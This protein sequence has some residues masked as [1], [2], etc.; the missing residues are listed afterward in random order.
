[1]CVGPGSGPNLVCKNPLL[2]NQHRSINQRQGER[3]RSVNQAGSRRKKEG[4]G[5][6]IIQIFWPSFSK[7]QTAALKVFSNR[8]CGVVISLT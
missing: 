6:C 5:S 4:P 8:I 1:M 7:L 2:P 3:L